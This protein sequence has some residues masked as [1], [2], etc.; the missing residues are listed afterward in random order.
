MIWIFGLNPKI[1]AFLKIIHF[2]DELF[3]AIMDL[4][5]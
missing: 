5:P 2:I 1:L 3:L 4:G